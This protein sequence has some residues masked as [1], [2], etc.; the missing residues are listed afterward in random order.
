L[1]RA[2]LKDSKEEPEGVEE[3]LGRYETAAKDFPVQVAP[4]S[5]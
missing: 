1:I 4:L 2:L 5:F 3:L